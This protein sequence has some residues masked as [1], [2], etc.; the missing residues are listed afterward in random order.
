L[1]ENEKLIE[2]LV[3]EWRYQKPYKK[4]SKY[5]NASLFGIIPK[6]MIIIHRQITRSV[7][8]SGQIWKTLLA[9]IIKVQ[10]ITYLGRSENIEITSKSVTKISNKP[11]ASG[12]QTLS[13]P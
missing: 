4:S 2:K 5:V 8:I 9:Q 10:F 13:F 3:V 7:P 12:V 11:G 1:S 6:E